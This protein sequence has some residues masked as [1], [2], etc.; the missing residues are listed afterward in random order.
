MPF[1]PFHT[2]LLNLSPLRR[3][4]LLSNSLEMDMFS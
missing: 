3:R 1:L 2:L 4:L